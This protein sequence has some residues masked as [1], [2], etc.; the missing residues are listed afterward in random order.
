MLIQ[1]ECALK[2]KLSF[3]GICRLEMRTKF[4]FQK[5]KEII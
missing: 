3:L 1:I 5:F 2:Q 4:E